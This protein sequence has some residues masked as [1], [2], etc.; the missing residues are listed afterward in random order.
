MHN[1][2]NNLKYRR[3][4][5]RSSL[6]LYIYIYREREGEREGERDGGI[7]S[8]ERLFEPM[9]YLYKLALGRHKTLVL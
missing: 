1:Y 4:Q 8:Y 6:S 5:N 9:K 2:F 7:N 3:L